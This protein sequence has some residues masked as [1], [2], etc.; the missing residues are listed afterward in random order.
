MNSAG[1]HRKNLVGAMESS[2]R[3]L[4]TDYLDVYWVHAR[5]V[6]TPIEETMRALD[7]QVRAGKVLYVG[8]SDWHAWEVARANTLATMRG[9]TAFSGLQVPYSLAERTVER[10]LIPMASQLGLAVTAWS[11]LGGGR[12]SRGN[13]DPIAEVLKSVAGE[14]AATAGQVAIAWLRRRPGRVI[15]IIG[16][17]KAEQM[18]EN[19]GALDVELSADDL[20]ALDKVSAVDLGFPGAF[21]AGASVRDMVYGSRRGRIEGGM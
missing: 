21:L 10:E 3:R 20:A 18:R 15:P 19:L 16:A 9:W 2:L 7:D 11:P 5:D 4:G 17:S 12:L 8:V 13:D 6:L 14:V 1:S